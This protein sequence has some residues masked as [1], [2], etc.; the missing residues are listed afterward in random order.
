MIKPGICSVTFREKSVEE[1]IQ[2]TVEAGLDGIEW[3]GDRHVPAGDIKTA[4]R[5]GKLTRDAGLVP[6]SYGSYYFAFDLP[7][8]SPADCEPTVEAAVALGAPA[9]RIWAGSMKVEEKTPDYF[10]TVV[11]QSCRMADLA[12]EVG[13]KVAYEFH[14][15]TYTETLEG[16]LKLLDAA[17]HPNLYAYWQPRFS[18]DL[19]ERLRQIAV[20]KEKNSLLNLH[21]YHWDNPPDYTRFPLEA[22][23]RFWPACFKAADDVDTE[24][25]A[26]IE[27]VLDNDPARFLHD[28]ATLKT[29]L[30]QDK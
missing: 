27:F 2:L 6:A 9:I 16:L 20:L 13:I 7:G 15:G 14:P 23:E 10:D 11:Q 17:A 26:L 18:D 19:D 30:G 12:Q 3:G 8:A 25:F 21:V 29:W 5:V 24:R 1:V 22:G 28:A 4:E